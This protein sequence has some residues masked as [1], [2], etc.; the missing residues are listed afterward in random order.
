MKIKLYHK[1]VNKFHELLP[2]QQV[3][4]HEINSKKIRTEIV[5]FSFH[6]TRAIAEHFLNIIILVMC[7]KLY[8]IHY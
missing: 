1:G 6:Y 5:M 2:C 8:I 3:A 4:E 7:E